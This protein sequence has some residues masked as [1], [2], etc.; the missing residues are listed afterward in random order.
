MRS[1]EVKGELHSYYIFLHFD[2]IGLEWDSITLFA[3]MNFFSLQNSHFHTICT[4]YIMAF[5]LPTRT[6]FNDVNG[7]R[8]IL[9]N[10]Q[11]KR[12]LFMSSDKKN[13]EKL[14]Q[15]ENHGKRK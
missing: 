2:L 15:S 7:G 8:N 6:Y 3:K 11:F 14:R 10:S 9:V 12:I 13:E 4:R 1:G 5:Y